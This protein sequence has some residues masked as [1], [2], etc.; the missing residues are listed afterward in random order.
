MRAVLSFHDDFLNENT[1]VAH[2][3]KDKGH[4][5]YLLPEFHCELNPTE[6]VWGQAKVYCHAYTNITLSRL[7]QVIDPALDSVTVDNI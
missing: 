6:R 7:R 4:K 5:A 3:L 2:Y 1:I